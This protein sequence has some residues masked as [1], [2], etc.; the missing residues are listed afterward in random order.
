MTDDQL[1]LFAFDESE[2]HP[3]L[4]GSTPVEAKSEFEFYNWTFFRDSLHASFE[5]KKNHTLWVELTHPKNGHCSCLEF[6]KSGQCT[7]TKNLKLWA[8]SHQLNPKVGLT[9]KLRNSQ[10]NGLAQKWFKDWGKLSFKV[11]LPSVLEIFDQSGVMRV[12]LK[13]KGLGTILQKHFYGLLCF[14]DEE[15]WRKLRLPGEVKSLDF[16]LFINQNLD[17]TELNLKSQNMNTHSMQIDQ[18]LIAALM[19]HTL[20][21]FEESGQNPAQLELE[22]QGLSIKFTP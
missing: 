13:G 11:R 3:D 5:D 7:H 15:A 4:F 1:N 8:D 20:V 14:L 16:D 19:R 17:S 18:S 10:Y 9:Q 6:S 2:P 21:F 12:E 22:N